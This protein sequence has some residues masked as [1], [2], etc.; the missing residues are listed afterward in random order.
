VGDGEFFLCGPGSPGK[1]F[2]PP[3]KLRVMFK[4][5][6]LSIYLPFI[7]FEYL[8]GAKDSIMKL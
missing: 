2:H 8:L 4:H 6:L 5:A 1:G 7:E 3:I